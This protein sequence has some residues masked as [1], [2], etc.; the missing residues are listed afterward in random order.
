[1]TPSNACTAVIAIPRNGIAGRERAPIA[2]RTVT[3]NATL[4]EAA[5]RAKLSPLPKP[6]RPAREKP[7][8]TPALRSVRSAQTQNRFVI[9]PPSMRRQSPRFLLPGVRACAEEGHPLPV[10]IDIAGQGVR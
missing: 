10:V 4:R 9:Q 1:M 2:I 8:L 5:Y 7:A 6:S 3:N